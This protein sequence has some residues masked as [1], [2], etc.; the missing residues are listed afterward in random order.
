MVES[1]GDTFLFPWMGTVVANTFALALR[2]MGLTASLRRVTIEVQNTQS[3]NVRSC[4]RKLSDGPAPDAA[5]LV[6][7]SMNLRQQKYDRFLSRKLV[8]AGLASDRLDPKSV[9]GVARHLL[10]HSHSA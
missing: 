8:A 6:A 2:A 10:I 7:R 3:D 9:P 5:E 4:L 1:D